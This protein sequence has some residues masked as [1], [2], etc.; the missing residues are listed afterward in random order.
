MTIYLLQALRRPLE[1]FVLFFFV[2]RS[3]NIKTIKLNSILRLIIWILD[4]GG[5]DGQVPG[6]V[7][8]R[9]A[10]GPSLGAQLAL[11]QTQRRSAHHPGHQGR[12][13]EEKTPHRPP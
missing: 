2:M 3:R 7:A 6:A 5:G 11:A 8:P 4:V 9:A 10:P 13:A 12:L 1:S